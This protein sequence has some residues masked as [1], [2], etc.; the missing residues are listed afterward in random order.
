MIKSFFFATV[1][2]SVLS[3]QAQDY[4]ELIFEDD[5]ERNESQEDKDEIGKG[6]GTNSKSRAGGNK[7]VDL[8]DGAMY[9]YIHETA[10]HGVSVTHPA[11]FTDGAVG[12]K[13]MLE[14]PKDS[15]GLNFADLKYKPV[16]AGHLFV[17]K[18]STKDVTIQDL[19]TGNMD[20][21]IREARTSGKLTSEQ[22]EMLKGKQTKVKN[23]LETG[24]W[25]DLIAIVDG[26]KMSVSIDGKEVASFSSE[27]IA[28]PT[29]RTLRLA[30]GK[31]A[32]V[33]DVKIWRK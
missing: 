2:F 26:D 4:G 8:R 29:K 18:V 12:M 24:K 14:N 1:L 3:I 7:Q 25:Y 6:W 28:H 31:Q 11:E 23:A 30:V 20:L 13:F 15:L 22:K 9:I 10:D 27:G 33:D 16:H 32:V 5:F 19:K 21:K 17:V